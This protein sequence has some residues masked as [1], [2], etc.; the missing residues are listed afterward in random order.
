MHA[1]AQVDA[2]AEL[3][4]TLGAPVRLAVLVQLLDGPLCVHELVDALYDAGR[5]VSQPL[6]SQHLRRLRTAAL[7]VTSRRGNEVLYALADS[8]VGHIVRD[9]LRHV[10][11]DTD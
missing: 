2:A 4:R 3:L 10:D 5:P 11:H 8:H 6:V 1:P 7:V 9:A